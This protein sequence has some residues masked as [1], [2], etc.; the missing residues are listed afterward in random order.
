MQK[1]EKLRYPDTDDIT[2]IIQAYSNILF[3]ICI[4]ILKNEQDVQDVLQETYIRYMQKAPIFEDEEQIKAWLI[5]VAVNLCKD[6]LRFHKRNNY[7]DYESIERYYQGPEQSAE[8]A[9]VMECLLKLNVKYKAI[10]LLHY[11]EG[12]NVKEIAK[13]MALTESAVKKRMQRGRVILKNMLSA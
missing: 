6:F 12:Y 7:M 13:I 11:V 9:E 1:E 5:R 8:H 2:P 10:L 3:R 4:I